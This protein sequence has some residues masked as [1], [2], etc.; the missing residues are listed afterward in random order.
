MAI[1]YLKINYLPNSFSFPK[2]NSNK[3]KHRN[4][5]LKIE[6]IL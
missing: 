1:F 3:K 4:R 2:R 5:H 6:I